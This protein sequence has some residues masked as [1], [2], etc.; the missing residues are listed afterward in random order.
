MTTTLVQF[1]VPGTNQVVDGRKASST[2]PVHGPDVVPLA[3]GLV[4]FD[5]RSNVVGVVVKLVVALDVADGVGV[6]GVVIVG[7]GLEEDEY[8]GVGEVEAVSKGVDP[9][10]GVDEDEDVLKPFL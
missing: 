3:R 5:P 10:A 9:L 1:R 8:R 2:Q 6:V 7:F 4:V